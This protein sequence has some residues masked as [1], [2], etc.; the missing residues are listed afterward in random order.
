MVAKTIKVYVSVWYV[1]AFVFELP[2]KNH[3]LTDVE[4]VN[5]VNRIRGNLLSYVSVLD[6]TLGT[7]MSELFLRDKN[8]LALWTSTVFDEDR[9]ASFGTKIFWL[10]RILKHHKVFGKKIDKRTRCKIIKKLDEIRMIR[11]D[12]AH[13]HALNKKI[14]PANVKNRIIELYDVEHGIT[15]PR[16]FKMER[17]MGIIN[18]SWVTDQL[19]ILEV[20]TTK[21]RAGK[22]DYL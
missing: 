12:F 11:N 7:I 1:D 22:K 3:L 16:T 15:A 6:S 9:T 2:D 20:A 17:I 10:G 13:T 19:A 14:K 18:D 8:D 5:L 4:Y 21:I